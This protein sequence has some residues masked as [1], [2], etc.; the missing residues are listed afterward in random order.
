MRISPRRVIVNLKY[1]QLK[2]DILDISSDGEGII[3]SLVKDNVKSEKIDSNCF[4]EDKSNYDS[5]S[6][7]FTLSILSKSDE[8]SLI[9]DINERIKSGGELFIWD[10]VKEKK[11]IVRD[12]VIAK[13]PGGKEKSFE[14]MNL[15]P[16]AEFNLSKC[17]KLL[18]KYFKIEESLI[19]DKVIYIRAVRKEKSEK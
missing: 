6:I 4:N 5:C 8:V 12:R 13:F 10:R 15:N 9:E 18:E 11:E 7:F 1:A 17:E 2:G 16:F 3:Y 19:W 14:F